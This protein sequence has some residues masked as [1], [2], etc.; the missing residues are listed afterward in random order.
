MMANASSGAACRRPVWTLP[1]WAAAPSVVVPAS[2]VVRTAILLGP[3]CEDT[4]FAL[5]LRSV[6]EAVAEAARP[7]LSLQ[8]GLELGGAC[9][10][11]HR[12]TVLRIVD[13]LLSNALQH[14]LRGRPS[15]R[16]MVE[17]I[18]G[19]AELSVCVRDDGCGL[20]RHV[21]RDG[22]G[23]TMLRQLGRLHVGLADTPYVTQATLTMAYG[24]RG[25]PRYRARVP[26]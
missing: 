5:A 3:V 2:S 21:C 12:Q 15:G 1:R 24:V 10:E 11:T 23:F 17:V 16:A 13:E 4:R 18:T 19:T 22:N 8:I 14:G 25:S 6:C 26:S 9:P 20:D 7:E